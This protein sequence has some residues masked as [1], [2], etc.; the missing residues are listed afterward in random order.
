[1]SDQ[2]SPL[3]CGFLVNE[4]G[5]LPIGASELFTED[6]R[7]FAETA[8]RFALDEVVAAHEVI[9][10]PDANHSFMAGLLR[11]AGE[12]GLLMIDVPE[13]Y[14]GLGMDVTTSMLCAENLSKQ[15]SFAVSWGAHVGI[16][17]LPIVFFGS[18]EQKKKWL[19]LLAT[20]DKLA[21]YALTEPGSGSDA[22]AAK[23]RA[24]LS[25]DGTH[26]VLTG[27]KMWITNAG[28]ADLFTVFCQVD[29]NK[30]TAF[31]VEADSEGLSLGAEEHKMGI[32]GS[33]TRMV[34][35]DGV[36][37]PV[38]NLLGQVGRGHKIAFNILNVGRFKLGVG[39]LGGSKVTLGY[40][41]KYA[42]ERKQFG[43][44]IASFGAI[45]EKLARMA[46]QL[47]SLES[48]CY[49]LAKD[50]DD[51]I[52]AAGH[53]PEQVMGAIEEFAVE[54]SIL[55]VYGSE[56]QAYCVDEAVQIHGGYGYSAE[57]AVECGYRDARI[58][59]IFEG[60]NEINRMLIPGMVLKRTMKGQLPLFTAVAAADAA[61]AADKEPLVTGTGLEREIFLTKKAKTLAVYAAN[62]AIQKHMAD[63]KDQQ[64][65]LMLMADMMIQVYALDSTVT[66]TLQLDPTDSGT[67]LKVVACRCVVASHYPRVTANAEALLTHLAGDDDA[68][69]EK[70]F[71]VLDK[72]SYR[73][74]LDGVALRRRIAD[75]V[76]DRQRYP[77]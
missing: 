29:D 17:S 69:R 39:C 58:Q 28:F 3:G 57:Y 62:Q 5:S 41:V 55:K 8:K 46:V 11:K 42:L 64:E 66:R 13:E 47:Y 75:A 49:R 15:G 34:V 65:L 72:L 9:E 56:V 7:M 25:D 35:L 24:V 77:M 76:V 10:H 36:K 2:G 31:L 16:G 14:G 70:H 71:A 59:R 38:G 40:S 74:G 67:S 27:S 48:C 1:L 6:Q 26:Y 37:V 51:T 12:L 19:P 61:A 50:I 43:V 30:F 32:K 4:V 45:R 22:L 44:P 20:G 54:D 33:S 53:G 63:L 23:T 68:L 60:T 18:D 73:T 21:A 52:E